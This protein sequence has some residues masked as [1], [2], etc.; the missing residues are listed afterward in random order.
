M[1]FL[2]GLVWLKNTFWFR[3]CCRF[4][5][6]LV[7]TIVWKTNFFG[8]KE[9]KNLTF[10]FLPPLYYII[11]IITWIYHHTGHMCFIF[12]QMNDS[13]VNLSFSGHMHTYIEFWQKEENLSIMDKTLL[14]VNLFSIIVFFRYCKL[15]S[16]LLFVEIDFGTQK[17]NPL[18][19]FVV[20]PKWLS[21]SLFQ[22]I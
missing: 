21:S 8:L 1:F 16:H 11:I 13:S 9:R 22:L 15:L 4:A 3:C 6:N 7:N 10:V 14:V 18:C 2:V 17:K 5:Y 12:I 19:L 20:V